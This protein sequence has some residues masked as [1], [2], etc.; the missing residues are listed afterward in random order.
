MAKEKKR[1]GTWEPSH[2][3]RLESKKTRKIAEKKVEGQKKESHT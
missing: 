1:L 3:G 2:Q